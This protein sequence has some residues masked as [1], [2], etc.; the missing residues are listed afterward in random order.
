MNLTVAIIA[1]AMV[2]YQ[3]TSM[4]FSP[5]RLV[6]HLNTFLIFSL[7][8]V[9]LPSLNTLLQKRRKH[10]FVFAL[11]ILLFSMMSLGYVYMFSTEMETSILPLPIHIVVIAI[12]IIAVFVATLLS[13]GRMIPIV[14]AIFIAYVL[15]GHYLPVPFYHSPLGLARIMSWFGTSLEE[16]IYGI[17]LIISSNIIFMFVLFGSMLTLTGGRDFFLDLGI[18]VGRRVTGGAA[19][20]ATISS[21]LFG[22][23]SGSPTANVVVTG[24]VTIPLMKKTGFKPEMAGA[25][26]A[27]AS[28]GGSIMPPVMAVV[29]FI[30][31]GITGIPYARI[32]YAAIIP[33]ALYY[34]SCFVGIYFY[35]GKE[36]LPLL[37]EEVDFRVIMRKAP[38]FIVP[39]GILIVLLTMRLSAQYAAAWA[40]VASLLLS[41]IS[42][43][44]R[45][46]LS[47]LVQGLTEGAKLASQIGLLLALLGIILSIF[48]LTA[49]GPKLTSF[50]GMSFGENLIAVLVLGMV[51]SLVIGMAVPGTGAYTLVALAIAPALVRMGVSVLQAHF[52]AL[53]FAIIGYITPPVAPSTLI[54]CSIAK[55]PFLK[56]ALQGVRLVLGAYVVPFLFIFQPALLGQYSGEVWE[57]PSIIVSA[58]IIITVQI[59]ISNYY[60]T[61][62]RLQ[63][64][65]LS[66]IALIAFLAYFFTHGNLGSLI[67]GIACFTLLTLS[68]WRKRNTTKTLSF[69]D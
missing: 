16:G 63:E 34:L 38:L 61:R 39:F 27:V 20:M 42:K 2:I 65:A 50:I 23:V 57:I 37:Q 52:F 29:A 5:L 26:E 45:P 13:F 58:L 48:S 47:R 30:M 17:L 67:A 32:A 1:M 54:A 31:A 28:S 41:F 55:S 68:Q 69:R 3:L 14:V 8:L 25:V 43:D 49:L 44:T 24:S 66:S 22:S 7:L 35:A 4:F 15:W 21:A 10:L 36:K 53:Y 19:Q 51:I 40:M 64:L 33:A 62:L 46:S 60:F 9:F 18:L 12:I 11:A 6:H 56:T 59:L